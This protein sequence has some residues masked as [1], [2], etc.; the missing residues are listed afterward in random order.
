MRFIKLSVLLILVFSILLPIAFSEDIRVSGDSTGG[1]EAIVQ[2][3]RNIITRE[4]DNVINAVNANTNEDFKQ[5]DGTFVVSMNNQTR[6]L[7][8]G[9]FGFQLI[10]CSGIM[11]FVIRSERRFKRID[12]INRGMLAHGSPQDANSFYNGISSPLNIP[13]KA[14]KPKSIKGIIAFLIFLGLIIIAVSVYMIYTH[15]DIMSAFGN[16][17]NVSGV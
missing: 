12:E 1:N 13:K 15:P 14:D 9:I 2:Q 10:I 8:L 7:L 16:F 17:T 4:N 6:K 5:F 11:Y 3:I